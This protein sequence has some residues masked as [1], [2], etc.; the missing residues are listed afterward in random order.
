MRCLDNNTHSHRLQDVLDGIRDLGGELF[1]D[2]KSLCVDLHHPSELAN[3]NNP[4]LR[5][6]SDVG[7]ADDRYHVVLAVALEADVLQDYHLVVPLHFFK[8]A[9]EKVDRVLPVACEK[10]LIRASDTI[11]RVDQSLS[12]G[13]I[14]RPLD[15]RADGVFRFSEAGARALPVPVLSG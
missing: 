1:L 13:V 2:L 15:Q 14:P 3:S 8:R 10:F 6:I 4:V 7:F 5:K 11:R 12:L 9:L